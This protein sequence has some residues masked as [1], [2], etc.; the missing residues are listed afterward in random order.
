MC[1]LYPMSEDT[2]WAVMTSSSENLKSVALDIIKL[3]WSEG[4]SQSKSV[5]LSANYSIE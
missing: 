3:H 1:A 2:C 4:I 5:S